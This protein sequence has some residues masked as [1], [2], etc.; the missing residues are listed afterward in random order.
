MINSW[1]FQSSSLISSFHGNLTSD[2]P[3]VRVVKCER[4]HENFFLTLSQ[5]I[6]SMEEPSHDE[7]NSDSERD[8]TEKKVWHIP[9][10]IRIGLED[11]VRTFMLKGALLLYK[12]SSHLK[13]PSQTFNLGD[14]VEFDP[15]TGEGV[16][17]CL[18]SDHSGFYRTLYPPTF[19][20]ALLRSLRANQ[21]K[22]PEVVG[23]TSDVCLLKESLHSDS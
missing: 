1:L 6:F 9:V 19:R 8:E 13:E 10:R 5:E 11:E 16:F 12:L 18:N 4:K 21:L 22:E 20:K 23:I 14:N 15:K 17:I 2:F 3:L 7:G